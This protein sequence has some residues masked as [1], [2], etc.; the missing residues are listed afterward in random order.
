MSDEG[1]VNLFD[2]KE[3]RTDN[4]IKSSVKQDIENSITS[5]STATEQ[6]TKKNYNT[7][8]E[9]IFET[10]VITINAETRYTHN[11]P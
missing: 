8:N 3:L 4:K 10:I 1:V 9:P 6:L 11:R 2:D 7:I 5:A